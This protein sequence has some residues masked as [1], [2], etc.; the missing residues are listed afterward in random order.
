MILNSLPTDDL[1]CDVCIVGTGPVGI[2]VALECERLGLSVLAL[3]AGGEKEKRFRWPSVD[4][5]S[6]RKSHAPVHVTT[7]SAFGGTSWAWAGR[8]VAFDDIDFHDRAHVAH[9]GWPLTHE[10]VA[11]YYESAARI[12][13]CRESVLRIGGEQAAADRSL[14]ETVFFVS[15]QPKLAI[16]YW[17]HFAKSSS[18]TL[19]LNSRVTA[20]NLDSDG[21]QVRSLTVV[22][23]GRTVVLKPPR[24]VLAAGGLKTTQLLLAAQRKWPSHFGGPDGALGRYYMGHLAGSI[25]SVT[26]LDSRSAPLLPA[27]APCGPARRLTISAAKQTSE[28]LLNVAFWPNMP[29]FYDPSHENGV[30]SAALLAFAVPKV[31]DLLAGGFRRSFLGPG[32]QRFGAHARNVMTS[33]VQTATGIGRLLWNR[34]MRRPGLGPLARETGLGVYTLHYHAESEPNRESCVSLSDRVDRDGLP[35]L[36]IDL[37]FGDKDAS[38]IVRAHDVL[39]RA[40]RNTGHASI[41]YL[42]APDERVGNVLSQARDGYHQMGT[43]RMGLDPKTSVVDKDCRVH[44]LDNLYIASSSVFPTGGHANPTLFATALGVRLAENLAHSLER[45]SASRRAFGSDRLG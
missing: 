2:A 45:S 39:D 18:I 12:L 6:N 19:A 21:N 5:L 22:S 13:N 42:D 20:V 10:A 40:L 23:G 30:L 36:K 35:Q 27:E 31:G 1:A 25:A 7:R 37:K 16:S 17:D 32:P 34:V 41:D 26:F 3:E 15:S 8:C 11:P 33:P 38:S 43:T 44:G 24:V 4:E 29:L 28:R 14:A 9:S